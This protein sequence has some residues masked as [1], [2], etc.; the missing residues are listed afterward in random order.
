MSAGTKQVGQIRPGD[1]LCLLFGSDEEQREVLTPFLVDGLA[2][3]EK[4]V[5]LGDGTAPETLTGWLGARGVDARAAWAR[6]QLEMRAAEHGY[7]RAGR[8]DQRHLL[9][10]LR[11]AVADARR[12]GYSG[13]RVAGEMSWALR[14]APGAEHLVGYEREAQQVFDT[15][16]ASAL[17]QY[18]QRLFDAVMV[19]RLSGCHAFLATPNAVYQDESVCVMPTF[20]PSGARVEGIV[21]VDNCRAV[22]TALRG[23]AR[24]IPGDIHLDLSALAFI[25]VAG[26]R[27]LLEVAG[28][29]ENRTLHIENLAPTLQQVVRLVGWDQSPGLRLCGEVACA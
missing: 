21:E 27:A 3:G 13:L 10:G 23:C 4:I 22:A 19:N 11:T 6:G 24:R 17:C 14:G 7:T 29:L 15:G 25:D 28:E 5:Y 1:H 18:D 2:R 16:Q 8:F 9:T 20:A 12:S 26:L